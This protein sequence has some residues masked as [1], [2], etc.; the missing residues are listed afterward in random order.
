MSE[1][2]REPTEEQIK[3]PRATCSY[4]NHCSQFLVKE[5]NYSRQYAHLYAQRL[6]CFYPTLEKTVRRKWGSDV[7][8][9]KLF[10]LKKGEKCCVIGTIFK[11]MELRPN[12]LREIS[13]EHNLMPQPVRE[14]YISDK[15]TLILEDD[16][17]R[18]SLVDNIDVSKAIIGTVVAVLGKEGDSSKFEVEEYS[19]VDLPAQIPAAPPEQDRFVLLASGLGV[20]QAG[21]HL[22]NLQMMVDMVTGNLGDV[23][24]QKMT[25]NI[26]R[27][28][29]AGNSL[30][31]K[32]Q[33]KGAMTMAKYL[34]RNTSPISS[35]AVKNL[36][37]ILAQLVS[38]IPV[39]VMPGEQDPANFTLPQQ[40][41]HRCMFPRAK[42][43]S[44]LNLVTNPY[45]ASIGSFRFSGTSGQNVD[46]I[47]RITTIDDRM[48]ILETTL[49]A[50][51]MAPTAPD[52]LGCYP[53][54][55]ND[56]F[57]CTTCPHVYFAGNQPKFQTKRLTDSLGK[58]ITLI[59]IPEFHSTHTCVLLN[60]RTMECQP[61]TFDSDI[62]EE[63]CDIEMADEDA[64]EK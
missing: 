13:D 55:N 36:D 20:G 51:H 42:V 49:R 57:I 34:T 15:D 38:S 11:S 58:K 35:A 44:S 17:Q 26:V 62:V 24:D 23:N 64:V 25:A 54:F 50:G 60:L 29:I 39:D 14:K 16:L 37:D 9:R 27:I 52:L 7:N 45:E 41:L 8:I 31:V 56:P 2:L 59:C 21:Q 43:Y 28:I 12:I 19:F 3:V 4:D 46:S 33:D 53:Y 48:E 47:Y 22:M 40:P 63:P 61:L 30:S 18:I 5:R 10:E 32:N 1:L 6:K